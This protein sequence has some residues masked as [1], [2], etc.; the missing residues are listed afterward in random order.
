MPRHIMGTRD[1]HNPDAAAETRGPP[2]HL[3]CS[4]G[5]LISD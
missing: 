1:D 4:N 3:I 2:L 5:T